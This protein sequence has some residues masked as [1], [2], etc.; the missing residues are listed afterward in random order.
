LR[1]RSASP[2]RRRSRTAIARFKTIGAFTRIR[3]EIIQILCI[4]AA[5]SLENAHLYQKAQET[6]N[7]LKIA[8]LQMVQNEKMTTLGL[9]IARQIVVENMAAL[10]KLILLSERGQS[11]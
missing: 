10:L 5:I 2:R 8:Q 1:S 4:Q 9:A 11:L 7:E 3:I 6:L